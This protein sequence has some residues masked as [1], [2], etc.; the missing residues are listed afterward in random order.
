MTGSALE[1]L[2]GQLT[3]I[4]ASHADD[5]AELAPDEVLEVE[6]HIHGACRPT[7]EG[8]IDRLPRVVHEVVDGRYER[9]RSVIELEPHRVRVVIYGEHTAP[10]EE[11]E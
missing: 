11:S 1:R 3:A 7:V 9:V 2:V 6:A 5:L 8:A 10:G 4:V